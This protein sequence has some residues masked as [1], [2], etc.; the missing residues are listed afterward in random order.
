MSELLFHTP[1]WLPTALIALGV[2]LFIAGN[3]RMERRVRAAGLIS[4][5][6]AVLL[7]LVSYLVDTDLERA[8]NGSR[9]LVASVAASDWA[10][11]QGL[12]DPNCT[13]AVMNAVTVYNN[14]DQIVRGAQDAVG[15]YG[16]R[17]AGI[18][19]LEAQQTGPLITVSVDV[20]TEQDA[21]ALRPLPSSWQFEWQRGPG[22]WSITR[23][24]NLRIY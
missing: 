22:G 13:V 3:N 16:L 11:M 7:M 23:I 19:S 10:R 21:T 15:R 5:A 1:W 14:R 6:A 8:E 2:V 4:M 24:T 12:L 18:R 9:Q 20:I 17:A